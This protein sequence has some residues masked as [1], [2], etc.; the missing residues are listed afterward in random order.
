MIP[1]AVPYF[2][3]YI[4]STADEGGGPKRWGGIWNDGRMGAVSEV[5][6]EAVRTFDTDGDGIPDPGDNCPFT[7]NPGQ[8]DS[9]GDLVG[10][11]CDNCMFL[12]NPG[13]ADGDADAV[14]DACDN[15]PTVFNPGQ[16]DSDFDGTGDD[17]DGCP[18]DP[19]KIAPGVCGCGV[20]DGDTDGD[21][22]IDCL[23]NCPF[24]FNP[25][26]ADA[27]LD[28]VG[29]VCDNCVEVANP[30]Q[31]ITIA[32]TGDL[33]ASG[34]LTSSDVILMVNYV[35]KGGAAP[36]PCPAVAD[37]NCN[38]S[39]TSGDIITLVNHVFKGGAPPCNVCTAPGLGWSCP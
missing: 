33:N 27:D 7:A 30:N 19:A 9:D 26:Q 1:P 38:G 23:D 2:G 32:M 22:A 29:D 16:L 10:D 35:F 20:S 11:A 25:G 8:A 3:D 28:G 6:F 24:T 34:T 17:C 21:L 13:Q 4:G 14:G 12:F 15:C 18:F 39:V 37:C 31:L 36:S 5:F